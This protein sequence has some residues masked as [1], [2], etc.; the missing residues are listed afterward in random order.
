MLDPPSPGSLS[1]RVSQ[2]Q[3]THRVRRVP[4]PPLLL[5]RGTTKMPR[6]GRP[7]GG[8]MVRRANAFRGLTTT[9]EV[10]M[11]NMVET[12]CLERYLRGGGESRQDHPSSTSVVG[13]QEVP[14]R[15]ASTAG[16]KKQE[17][18]IETKHMSAQ[19]RHPIH[20]KFRRRRGQNGLDHPKT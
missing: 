12:A 18:W 1:S 5:R 19:V 3:N 8:T 16:S 13:A 14:S 4:V 10:G 20:H 9:G 7:R 2:N 15:H 17:A 6:T 11:G